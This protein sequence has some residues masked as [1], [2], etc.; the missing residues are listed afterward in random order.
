M[1]QIKIKCHKAMQKNSNLYSVKEIAEMFDVTTATV[2][3]W[4]KNGS[5]KAIQVGSTVR[6][7]KEV[8]DTLIEG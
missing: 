1:W 7:K 8:I 5:L 3:N 2:R 6:F 4:V